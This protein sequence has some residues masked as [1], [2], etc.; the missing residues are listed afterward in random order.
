MSDPASAPRACWCGEKQ[1]F[2][3]SD[4]FHVCKVCGTLV[5]AADVKPA[6]LAV[7][8]DAGELYSKDYWL[9][10][11]SERYGLPSLDQRAR[12]DLPERCVHWLNLLL[13]HRA[14]PAKVLEI[15]CAHGGYVALMRWAGYEASGTEMSPWIVQFARETFNV[16]VQAGRIEELNFLPESLDVIVLNDVVEHLPD[17]AATLGHC[18]QLLK[19]DGF[20]IIQTPEYKEHLSHADLVATKDIFLTHMDG[21]N[22]EHLYLF[23]R[24]STQQLWSR[25]GFSVVGFENPIFPYDL[26]YTA[27]RNALIVNSPETIS[28][29]LV[30][31]PTGRLVQALLDKA[32]ESN[33]RWWEIIRLRK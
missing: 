1:L 30:A 15:G 25:L 21:K 17:P 29:A 8:Q 23:S 16:P 12:L 4:E 10:R 9:K 20:F 18:A 19:P 13:K 5:T 7:T 24:R 26:F 6:D 33:D 31:H 32:F 11:Q 22:E 3:Y 14:P 2:A 28:A 27:S